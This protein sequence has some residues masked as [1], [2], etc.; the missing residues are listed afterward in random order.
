[1]A[2]DHPFIELRTP[3]LVLRRFRPADAAAFQRYRSDPEVARYQSWDPTYS[4]DEADAFMSAIAQTSP[5]T[6]GEWFQFAV[7]SA[8]SG[9]LI[10]DVGLL[11]DAGEPGVLE[12]GITLSAEQQGQGFATEMAT[13]V[14]AYAFDT[15]A[16]ASVRAVTDTRNDAS[17]RLLERLAFVRM[18]TDEAMFKGEP[19]REHTYQLDAPG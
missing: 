2:A 9:M 7:I 11:T 15:L 19:C 6:P 18:S 12:L 8:R 16:A 1:M 13:A 5:G 14:V 3:R 17:I 10:G 4:L